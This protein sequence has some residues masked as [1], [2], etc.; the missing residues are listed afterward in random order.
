MRSL[1]STRKRSEF[2]WETRLFKDVNLRPA[3]VEGQRTNNCTALVLRPYMLPLQM[4]TWWDT[5]V[6]PDC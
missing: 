6:A 2:R 3:P 5:S 4:Q 1:I